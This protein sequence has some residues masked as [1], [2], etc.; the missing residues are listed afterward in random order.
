MNIAII[1]FS[2]FNT[3]YGS[4]LQ[5]LALKTFLESEGHKVKFIKYREF[6]STTPAGIYNK[7]CSLLVKLYYWLYRAERKKRYE[8]F[9][10]F[11]DENLDHTRLFTSEEDLKKHLEP[12]DAYVCGSDQIWNIDSLGGLRKPYFLTFAPKGKRK[13][14]Y[15]PSMGEYHPSDEVADEIRTLLES[16]D[17]IS[18]RE[19]DSSKL[20]SKILGT[21]IQTVVDPTLLLNKEQWLTMLG[22]KDTPK[23]DYAV[24]YFVRRHPLAD[25]IVEHFQKLY[26]IPIYNLSDNLIHIKGTKSDFITCSPDMFVN[27]VANAKFCVGASF[28]LAAFS[29]IFDKHCYIITTG[30]NNSRI[31]ELFSLVE[32][33]D[34]MTCG[35]FSNLPD[36][37]TCIDYTRYNSCVEQSKEFI[38]NVLGSSP[39]SRD[40]FI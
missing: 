28:H 25:K 16:F 12:F 20:I 1:T 10:A 8:N 3:N 5:A 38:R 18:T 26:K 34:H 17:G 11:I 37:T 21:Y 27:L 9:R 22:K 13:V 31:S 2:D 19:K 30:H 36:L 33:K 40:I 4:I 32:R 35:D 23:G 7:V 24:C 15:A 14:A 39:D 6:H 29:T